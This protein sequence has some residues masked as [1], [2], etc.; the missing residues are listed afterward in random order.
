MRILKFE[1]DGLRRKNWQ[2]IQCFCSWLKICGLMSYSERNAQTVVV[3]AVWCQITWEYFLTVPEIPV[4]SCEC[5]SNG[6]SV[7]NNNLQLSNELRCFTTFTLYFHTELIPHRQTL[8]EQLNSWIAMLISWKHLNHVQWD[9]ICMRKCIG[10]RKYLKLYVSKSRPKGLIWKILLQCH[11]KPLLPHQNRVTSLKLKK[12][13][14]KWKKVLKMG[15]KKRSW[16][17]KQDLNVRKI[18]S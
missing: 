5:R 1:F 9:W 17:W 6:C 7:T 11:S 13:N 3:T 12:Y 14:L 10:L 4:Y 8:V 16:T 2:M 15:K 18:K